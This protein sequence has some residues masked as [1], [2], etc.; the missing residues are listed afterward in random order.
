MTLTF[1]PGRGPSREFEAS[2]SSGAD[3]QPYIKPYL[4]TIP[5][6]PTEMVAGVWTWEGLPQ[7]IRDYFLSFFREIKWEAGEFLWA[8]PGLVSAPV[9]R[10][11]DLSSVA[12]GGAPGSPRSYHVRYTWFNPSTGQESNASPSSALVVASD[13]LLRVTVP[14]FP[15]GVE[16]FRVY[17]ATTAGAEGLQAYSAERTWQEPIGGIV[18]GNAGPPASSTLRPV[19]KWRLTGPLREI[20]RGNRFTIAL[21]V[22]LLHA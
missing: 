3:V 7:A 9:H 10:G 16:A 14:I 6:T 8:P 5:R 21:P 1:D 22:E 4:Q 19:L 12:V 13:W 18:G 15:P 20:Q 11:P 17:V 2:Y